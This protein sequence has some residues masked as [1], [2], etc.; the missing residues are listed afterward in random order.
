M[1]AKKFNFETH[2]DNSLKTQNSTGMETFISESTVTKLSWR[3]VRKGKE[4]MEYNVPPLPFVIGFKS[5]KAMSVKP[6]G[7]PSRSAQWND[8]VM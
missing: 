6:K 2:Y 7:F 1:G 4:G 8:D 5:I 3:S